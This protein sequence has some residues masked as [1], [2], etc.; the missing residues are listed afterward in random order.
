MLIT[1]LIDEIVVVVIIIIII[2]VIIIIISQGLALSELT[3]RQ[4][5]EPVFF[6]RLTLRQRIILL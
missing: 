3:Y 6:I 1:C 2:I 5:Q 4:Q